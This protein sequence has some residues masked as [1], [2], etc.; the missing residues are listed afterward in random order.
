MSERK[1]DENGLGDELR[2]LGRTLTEAVK[3]VATSDEVRKLGTELRD[4]FRDAARNFDDALD[5]VNEREEVQ[6]VRQQ[7]ANVAQSLKSGDAQRE[8]SDTV[9]DALHTLNL[10]LKEMLERLQ[11]PNDSPPPAAGA[12]PQEEG[13]TGQTRR[14]DPDEPGATKS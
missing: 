6:R 2:E 7:A 3:S 5:R 12:T 10:R 11:P 14:L 8:I 9:G 13:Y 1:P 4:G